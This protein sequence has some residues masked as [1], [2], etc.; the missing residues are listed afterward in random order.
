MIGAVRILLM[1]ITLYLLTPKIDLIS[2]IKLSI[3]C[4]VFPLIFFLVT[5]V[6]VGSQ[7]FGDPS[8]DPTKVVANSESVAVRLRVYLMYMNR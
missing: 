4:L 6:R 1:F 5:M 3:E 7:R 8:D 2:R